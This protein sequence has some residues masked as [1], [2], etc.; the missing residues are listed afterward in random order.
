MGWDGMRWD[1]GWWALERK[2]RGGY[3]HGREGEKEGSTVPY[4]DSPGRARGPAQ[5]P[6]EAGTITCV[7]RVRGP[8]DGYSAVYRRGVIYSVASVSSQA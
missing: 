2:E 7:L 5:R 4:F 8:G 1:V 3:S 6:P